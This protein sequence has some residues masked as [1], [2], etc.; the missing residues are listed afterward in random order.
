[1]ILGLFSNL[2]DTKQPPGVAPMKS[3]PFLFHVFFF[4]F[5]QKI[6]PT[7]DHREG[8][9]WQPTQSL[10]SAPFAHPCSGSES[11]CAHG[12]AATSCGHRGLG[13]LA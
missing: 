2:S 8:L 11:G 7:A 13:G 3:T 6:G 1:M 10:S 4:E 9:E 12:P 5:S